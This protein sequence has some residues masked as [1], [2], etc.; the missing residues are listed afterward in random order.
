[1]EGKRWARVA[2]GWG[3]KERQVECKG[4]A[5]DLLRSFP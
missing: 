5:K 2:K 4:Q 3:E 1:V